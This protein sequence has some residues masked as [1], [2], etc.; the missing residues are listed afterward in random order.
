VSRTRRPI[1]GRAVAITGGARGIGAAIAAALTARGARVAIGDLDADAAAATARR[2]GGGAVGLALDVTD[3]DSFATFLAAAEQAHGALDVLVNNAG[4]MWV[5]PFDEEPE[6]TALAQF[7]V[8]L[9]G[10]IRGMKLALPAMRARGRGHVVNV[11]SSASKVLPRGEATYAATKH[12][13]YGYTA[14][15]RDELR[16]SGVDVSVVMPVIVETELA[17]GTT[18]GWS[19][20]LTPEQVAEAVVDALE[21]PRFEVWVPRSLGALV[22][23]NALVGQRARDLMNRLLI[24]D[25]ARRAD[26]GARA[27]YEARRLPGR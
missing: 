6:A 23:V 20:R 16:G 8:N 3:S 19:P 11:A 9:H 1:A 25:Q 14:I 26:R 18:S 12:A 4:I 5:G 2:V 24:P 21:R 7:D 10:T 17:V 22:R 27:D 15:V 13:V